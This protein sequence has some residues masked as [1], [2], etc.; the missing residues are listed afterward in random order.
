MACRSSTP[1][2]ST[3]PFCISWVRRPPPSVSVALHATP[4]RGTMSNTDALKKGYEAF[5]N[6]DA[7]G[8]K[9]LW[10]DDI[11][12][13][14]PNAEE[15]P[16]GGTHEGADAVLQMLGTIGETYESFEV[17]PDEWLESGETIVVLGHSSAKP[18]D[19]DREI[20]VPFVHVWRVPGGQGGGGPG[21]T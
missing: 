3:R 7:D 5:A 16:G 17:Q 10:T 12:W 4:G 8:M 9:A 19:G 20:K 18:K 21:P 15:L 1:R 2:P 14:G 13:E 11:R 6:G